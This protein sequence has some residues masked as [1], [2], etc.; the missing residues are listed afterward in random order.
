MSKT[1]KT[2]ISK[3]S[4]IKNRIKYSFKFEYMLVQLANKHNGIK[5]VDRRTKKIE[6]PSRPKVKFR[7]RL[8]NQ[9]RL[10]LNCIFPVELLKA[11]NRIK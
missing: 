11:P 6:I 7:F 5:S 3:N 9:K 8:G 2:F 1:Q 10:Q 4:I